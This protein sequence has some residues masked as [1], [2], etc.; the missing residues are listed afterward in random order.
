MVPWVHSALLRCYSFTSKLF[1][2]LR[3]QSE[4]KKNQLKRV[5]SSQLSIITILIC[6]P[7]LFLKSQTKL[8]T[9]PNNNSI[10]VAESLAELEQ[11]KKKLKW[12]EEELR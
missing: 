10:N 5:T 8:T 9:M 7:C 4:Y 12:Y 11:A 3:T 6:L 1:A 2:F